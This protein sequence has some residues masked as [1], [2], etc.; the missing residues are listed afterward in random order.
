MKIE[1]LT[2]E[3]IRSWDLDQSLEAEKSLRRELAFM[4]IGKATSTEPPKSSDL[5]LRKKALAR[6]LTLRRLHL[7]QKPKAA[8]TAASKK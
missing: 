8:S 4:R 5:R 6:I 3:K 1:E 7:S 2:T